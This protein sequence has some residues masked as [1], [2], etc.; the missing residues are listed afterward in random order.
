M[1]W[2]IPAA[3]SHVCE[4]GKSCD[5]TGVYGE[6]PAVPLP[7]ENKVEEPRGAVAVGNVGYARRFMSA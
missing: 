5:H 6:N 7:G 2:P 4:T 3:E 1:D